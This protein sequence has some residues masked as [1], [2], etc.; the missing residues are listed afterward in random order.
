MRPWV[1]ALR[2]Y[3]RKLGT[4]VHAYSPSAF[5]DGRRA[6]GDNEQIL[7]EWRQNRKGWVPT[8]VLLE[9][10]PS[11]LR[12]WGIMYSC[13]VGSLLSTRAATCSC[14]LCWSPTLIS[15]G[16]QSSLP[17]CQ[18]SHSI[19]Q[20]INLRGSSTSPAKSSRRS[21]IW[22]NTALCVL[23]KVKHQWDCSG[24]LDSHHKYTKQ[25]N[26]SRGPLEAIHRHPPW[27]FLCSC[28]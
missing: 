5:I 13:V 21:N 17:H 10:R 8:P 3:R 19:W 1:P 26:G 6:H 9:P 15:G 7:G 28:Q 25:P 22:P 20:H 23:L 18:G 4:M 2:T 12:L 24:N 11:T 27:Y 14:F 16:S